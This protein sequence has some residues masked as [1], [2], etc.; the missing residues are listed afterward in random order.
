MIRLLFIC[1][2][3]IFCFIACSKTASSSTDKKQ[4]TEKVNQ[5]Y[6]QYGK[7][8]ET[9]YNQPIPDDLF[10]PDLK[11][12][13]QNAINAS[14]ADIEKVKSSDHPDEKPLIFEGAMFSS[15]YE[16]YT[17]YKIQSMDIH[18]ASAQVLVRF[19]YNITYPTVSWTDTIHW[20]NVMGAGKLIISPL[21]LS[22]I[23]KILK[24][25]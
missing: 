20:W 2:S 1:V 17:A 8:N 14:K 15:L 11:K 5:L 13:L 9:V 21:I 10:S 7:S 4:I 16:G 6:S 22:E 18:N 24:Q 23:L 19:E 12:A 3:F 25:E